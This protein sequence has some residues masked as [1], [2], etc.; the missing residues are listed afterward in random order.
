MNDCFALLNE[1]R[2]PWLD[3]EA[4]KQ[5]FVSLSAELHPDRTHSAMA[6]ACA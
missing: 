5:R 1:P 4:L 6:T 3:S 2:R